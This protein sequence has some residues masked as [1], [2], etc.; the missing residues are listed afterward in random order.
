MND[1]SCAALRAA[2]QY[3]IEYLEGLDQRSVAPAPDALARLAE[4]DQ[5]L[6]DAPTPAGDVIRQ[7]HEI[8][9]PA[10]MATAGGA[11]SAS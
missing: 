9:S 6:G 8:G 3:G 2:A 10:T 11:S 5:P 7:L 1:E 4:L